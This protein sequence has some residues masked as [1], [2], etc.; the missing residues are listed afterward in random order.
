VSNNW[1][2]G[3]VTEVPYTYGYYRE[4]SPSLQRFALLI[5]GYAPPTEGPYL[6]LGFG[7]G[8][9]AC[10]HA[11]ATDCTVWG[12]DFNPTQAANAL[13]L[14]S[15]SGL[16]VQLFDDNFEQLLAHRSLPEFAFIAAHGIWSW[17]SNEARQQIVEILRCKL[18]VGGAAYFSYN[19]FPGWSAAYSLRHLLALQSDVMGNTGQGVVERLTNSVAFAQEIA[20]KGAAYFKSNP[21]VTD[22]LNKLTAYDKHYLAHEYFNK[23]WQ[24]MHFSEFANWLEPA[25]LEF[26][27]SAHL[28]EHVDTLNLL[29]EAQAKLKEIGNPGFRESVRDYFVNQQFRRDIFVRGNAKLSLLEQR[30]ALLETSVALL[31]HPDEIS[32]TISGVL[33]VTIQ[34]AIY[35][36]L[37]ELFATHKFRPHTLKELARHFPT[38]LWDQ[39]MQAITILI[40]A[41]HMH[42]VQREDVIKRAKSKSQS[43]NK[44]ICRR[45]RSN[46]EIGFLASPVIGAGVKMSRFELMFMASRYAGNHKPQS[47]VEEAWATLQS[48]GQKL[49]KE[50]KAL[51]TPEENT[52][53]LQAHAQKF[54]ARL[55][56]LMALHVA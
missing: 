55:P 29:P 15:A 42:P 44:E 12:T 13:S 28:L 19:T 10:I 50:G 5:Q 30:E 25:K 43:L 24:P 47:W 6:E 49:L 9:S 48:Q 31:V 3:Y 37:L 23:N 8:L 34:E 20:T 36:P 32:Y 11:A 39:L 38:L 1:N 16:D 41:G 4:L 56:I 7:Q 40:G 17:V 52:A 35:R 21:L 2:D 45:A 46:A 26:A 14:A 33:E 22:R 51:E 18:R 53:E 27:A 54:M